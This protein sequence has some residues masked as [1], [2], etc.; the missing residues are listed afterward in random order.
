MEWQT[1]YRPYPGTR[2]TKGPR[3]R[4]GLTPG[5]SSDARSFRD[6]LFENLR[7]YRPLAYR[8]R[9]LLVSFPLLLSWCVL[10]FRVFTFVN[11]ACYIAR[12]MPSDIPNLVK[13][14]QVAKAHISNSRF[15]FL[16]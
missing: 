15:G 13:S 16:V 3:K 6:L 11:S 10:Y 9:L 8:P 14:E 4:C 2:R 7:P 1:A 12:Y 5:R